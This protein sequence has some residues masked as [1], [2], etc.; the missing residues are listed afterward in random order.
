MADLELRQD[1]EAPVDGRFNQF[2]LFAA[3]D[4]EDEIHHLAALAGVADA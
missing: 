3:R 4:V 1:G 2:L